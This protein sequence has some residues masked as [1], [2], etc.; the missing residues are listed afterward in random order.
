MNDTIAAISGGTTASG[1]GIVRISGPEAFFV[2]GKIFRFADGKKEADKLPGQSVHYGHVVEDGEVLDEALVLILRAP[3]SFTA[4]DTVEI[5]AHGGPYVLSRILQAA[6]HAGARPAEPGEFTKR[7]FLNGRIDLSEAEAVMDVID[8]GT[9][10]ALRSANRQLSGSVRRAVE[11]LREGIINELARIEAAIDDPEHLALT[12]YHKTLPQVLAPIK[13]RIDRLLQSFESGRFLREGVK[14]AILGKPNVGKS[15]LLNM[16]AGAERA[17][18][19]DIPGT[20]RDL[21]KEEINVGG[22]ALSLADTAGLRASDDPIEQIG[23]ARAREAAA[24]ADLLFL[25]LDAS[26]ALT[27]EDEEVLA[28]GAGRTA[29]VLLNKADLPAQLSAADIKERYDLPVFAVS[30]KTGEGLPALTEEIR[31]RFLAG[32][33]LT[34]GEAIITNLRHKEA[35]SLARESLVRVEESCAQ[36]LPEDFYSIDL[37]DAYTAL[38]SIIG[39]A[40]GDDLID[41]IFSRFCMGK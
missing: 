3:H 33:L 13:E 30:A 23:V 29:V 32:E 4:E 1:I 15:S 6:V 9:A 37:M 39:A 21:L 28:T 26:Q 12:D 24:D 40:V 36:G 34:S 27:K 16:L 38:G 18:V 19:T 35:L 5:D 22:V 41:T 8:A 7:A 10:D 20:T 2:L 25:V 31:A 11:E 17:I 14:T